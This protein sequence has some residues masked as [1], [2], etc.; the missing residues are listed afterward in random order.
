MKCD[1][2]ICILNEKETTK[3]C[4]DSICKNTSFPF[5][6][7]L[8]DNASDAET[9]EYLESLEND[10]KV[11]VLLIRNEEN[12][13]NTK[14]VNQGISASNA[15]FICN[16]DND[17]YVSEG[18]LTEMVE[19]A[20][21]REDIGIVVPEAKSTR[22]PDSDEPEDIEKCGKTFEENRGSYTE[23]AMADLYC[24]LFKRSLIE[25]IG[26]WDEV[27]NPGYFDDTDFCMRTAMAD[28]KIVCALGSYVYH[29]E[30]GSFRRNEQRE[31]LFARNRVIFEQKYGKRK[32]IFYV[33]DKCD[34]ELK[35]KIKSETYAFA[36]K[37]NWVWVSKKGS[38]SDFELKNHSHIR[39]FDH[40]DVFFLVKEVLRIL[41]R[42]KRFDNI[43][44]T[45]KGLYFILRQLKGIHRA[46]V[47]LI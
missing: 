15:E 38:L 26:A 29:M 44:V 27:Y 25:K 30:R 7:V 17:T 31:E 40:S 23:M 46:K 9:K 14:A 4:I 37:A 33:I 19:V 16:L 22:M 20:R 3:K 1:I 10:P 6:L 5:R 35:E 18:W 42:K 21:K 2:I 47:C 8:I 28:L 24:A 12:L 13:G 45:N 41:F 36:K 39:Q 11:D 32:R 34:E 43:Y